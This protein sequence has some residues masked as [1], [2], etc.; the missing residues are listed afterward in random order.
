MKPPD[1]IISAA[2]RGLEHL[3]AGHGGD[4]LTEGTKD[5]ARRMAAGEISEDKIVKANA[6]G[7]RHAVDLQVGK[8]NNP[9][10]KEWPG[11]GAVAHYLWGINPLNP[12]PARE[13]FERKAEKIKNPTKHSY[14]TTFASILLS[15]VDEDV[16]GSF[17]ATASI[18]SLKK[19]LPAGTPTDDLLPIAANVAVINRP[20]KKGDI[21][22]TETALAV[23]KQF[24]NKFLNLE[25]DR[26]QIVGHVTDASLS[27]FDMSY[28][29]GGGSEYLD[30]ASLQ[31]D[32]YTPFNI[33]IA[34]YIYRTANPAVVR[35]I[36]DS[37]NPFSPEYLST[38]M[39]WEIGFDDY[40]IMLDNAD[41]TLA[42]FVKDETKATYLP[43]IMANGGSGATPDGR[44]VFRVLHSPN[45]DGIT[46]LGAGLTFSPAGEVA[47]IVTY[48]EETD[49]SATD[50]KINELNEEKSS[51]ITE[52]PVTRVITMKSITSF[53]DIE[54][55]TDET[56]KETSFANFIPVITAEIKRVSEEI[57]ANKN[58]EIKA[59]QDEAKASDEKASAA[60]AKIAN[61]QAALTTVQNE[62]GELKKMQQESLA[63][64][65]FN[66]RMNGF[67]TAYNLEDDVRAVLAA[68]LKGLNDEGFANYHTKFD[69][70]YKQ[71]KKVATAS[72]D[73]DPKKVA[74]IA[75]ASVVTPVADVAVSPATEQTLKDKW[76]AA[77]SSKNIS[78]AS[79]KK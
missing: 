27:K 12:K 22:L 16:A 60:E 63:A 10:D 72:F 66:A 68:D 64:D 77:F 49:A 11:A 54:S 36:M 19:L 52:S 61:L 25:H 56:A 53:K 51:Q 4:G 14:E 15:P 29:T 31:I 33:A 3:A 6:W 40:Y 21:M 43:Y 55:I 34:G 70:L 39:S 75:L 18:N 41:P 30:P 42:T 73:E 23:Y 57:E 32:D 74:E 76:A 35:T 48:G 71:N 1:Y 58:A 2:K 44:L 46:P 20:N 62:L 59:K 5:A 17:V 45:E 78:L 47:G 13:W 26:K 38:A 37:S 79:F 69:V 24:K 65:T 50:K 28:L 8:N 9:D 67:D 7:A